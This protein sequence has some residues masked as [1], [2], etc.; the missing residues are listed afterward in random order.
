MPN[1]I[2]IWV[3]KDVKDGYENLADF[4]SFAKDELTIY[5]DQEDEHGK[6]WYAGKWKTH[7]D[8]PIAM[9]FG[10]SSNAY[11]I[12]S[13]FENPFMDFS[14]AFIRQDQTI[15]E[16]T[17]VG[18][19]LK[20]FRIIHEALREL[21][22]E[23]PPSIMD[24]NVD[25]Q[26]RVEHLLK[27]S[28]C[29]DKK[30]YHYGGKLETLYCW[31]VKKQ[32][33]PN[34]PIRKNPF[35]RGIDKIEQLDEESIKWSE[36]RCP[37]MH[38]MLSLADCFAR[39]KSLK[40]KFYTSILVL[41]SFAPGR[42]S[43]INSLTIHSLQQD[44]DGK[45]Y[46]MWYSGK[47]YGD[48]KKWVPTVMIDAVKEAFKR[49]IEIGKPAR[50]AAKFAFDNPNKFMRHKGCVTP[51]EF[52]ENLPLNCTQFLN[53]MSIKDTE[54]NGRVINW[55]NLPQKWIKE[56]IT[57]GDITYSVLA[58]LINASYKNKDWPKNSKTGRPVW[59]NLCL[60][61]EYEFNEKVGVKAF[62]WVSVSVNQINDQLGRRLENQ[63]TLWERFGIK[64]EDD[65]E[66]NLTSH[67]LRVWLNT[68]AMNGGMSDYQL[69]MWSG[70]ADVRQ[71]RAYDGRTKGEKD[72]LKNQIML[73]DHIVPPSP[74]ALFSARLPVP[75]PSL[76]V[77]REGVADFT[78][79]GFCV[80]NFA[81]TPCTKS[82]ECI[83]CKDHLCMKGLPDTLENLEQ[84]ALLIAEQ[85]EAAKTAATD[86]TFG[87]DRWVTHLGW[88]LA[89]IRTIISNMKN[90][91]MP[92]GAVIRIPVAHDPSPTRRSLN[93]KGK[94]TELNSSASNNPQIEVQIKILGEF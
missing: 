16:A 47:G 15:Q 75:L 64:D 84:M 43:E 68:H 65:S 61:R 26:I 6:G 82:G 49:L 57:K 29:A 34:L 8:R 3:P 44:D 14:K 71:N 69:A 7:H 62:S 27:L 73:M 54:L 88:K 31:L 60:I 76:G 80:H 67:Q 45:Y 1:N 93:A 11:K 39:A 83:T 4:I 2:A 30:K 46:V 24:L 20:V 5:D 90:P 85:L 58:K 18:D 40:D 66:I 51:K 37:T 52:D 94:I 19:W 55:G 25:V 91:D 63:Q 32:I 78:G 74:L 48:T 22:R 41:L 35:S 33:L 77:A 79:L 86:I 42:G 72:R 70:R 89:H 87:A 10:F 38:Q 13:L 23:S 81:Q 21:N 28:N 17:N 9:V 12:E 92:N 59:E 53:A 56:L 36:E 50:E